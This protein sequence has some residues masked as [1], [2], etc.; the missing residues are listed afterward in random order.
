MATGT[1][2]C[3]KVSFQ[4][5]DL[6]RPPPKLTSFSLRED[7]AVAK[8][9]AAKK[10]APKKAAKKATKKASKKATAKKG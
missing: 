2:D 7:I 9:K 10:A 1:A 8:K 3:G 6:F 5:H 4:L